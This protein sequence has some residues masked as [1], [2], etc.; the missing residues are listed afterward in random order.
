MI[1]YLFRHNKDYSRFNIMKQFTEELKPK[2]DIFIL[3]PFSKNQFFKNFFKKDRIVNDF[4]ISNYDTYV[5][6]RKKITK[7]NPRAWWK[8]LQDWVNFR[9]SNY[10]LSDTNEHF[11]YWEKLFGTY[12][13]K[14]FVFPVLA[15]KDIYYPLENELKNDTVKILFYGSFIPLHGI[16]IILEA[17]KLLEQNGI[18][19]EAKII[20][21][22]QMYHKMKN[23][24][25]KL[26]LQQVQMNGEIIQEK[27][28][29]KEIREHDII[30]GIFGN[31]T[32][33]KS[34]VPNK[35]Y[36]ALASKKTIVTMRSEAINEF[37][38]ANELVT[39]DN[40]P[41]ELSTAL[42]RLINDPQLSN[43]IAL[44]GYNKFLNL[45]DK[46]K[47]EFENFI[48]TIDRK[49]EGTVNE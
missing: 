20:G 3:L 49:L 28:L 26:D 9:F 24:F 25:D 4:F 2:N 47:R 14:H 37:F 46:T 21:K 31:S 22:G 44:N 32:K 17:F 48:Y 36:Q 30:L 18:K 29:A 19:F 45:Y 43:D 11:K 39:C 6:D 27:E 41:K 34:V 42:T 35:V 5:Y 40:R 1:K 38:N 33:A 23:L 10:I 12:H 15:D 16:D 7:K 8:Y 13:G